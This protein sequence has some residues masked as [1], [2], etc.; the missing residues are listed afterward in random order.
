V[1]T[2]GSGKAGS[3]IIRELLSHGHA[4]TNVD[5]VPPAEPLCHFF[6]ADLSDPGAAVDALRRRH[7]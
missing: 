4:V 7:H 2:G 1:V 3:A 5:V 6:K